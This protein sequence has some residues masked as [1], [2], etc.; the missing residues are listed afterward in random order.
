MYPTIWQQFT[1]KM[2]KEKQ[3]VIKEKD[4]EIVLL[5]NTRIQVCRGNQSYLL[6]MLFYKISHEA[7][8]KSKAI[9]Q[10]QKLVKGGQEEP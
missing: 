5:S 6:I 10:E 2:I 4:S 3:Q 9:Q 1:N 7:D 8:D